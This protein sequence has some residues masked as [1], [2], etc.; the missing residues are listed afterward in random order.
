MY[1][2]HS[3][4]FMYECLAHMYVQ[5]DMHGD[6]QG[7]RPPDTGVSYRVGAGN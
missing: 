5:P 7:I 3:N 2:G 1:L 4:Y 6:Q